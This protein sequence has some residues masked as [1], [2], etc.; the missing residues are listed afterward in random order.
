MPHECKLLIA[1]SRLPFLLWL[2]RIRRRGCWSHVLF[3]HHRKMPG[4]ARTRIDLS[5]E[6]MACGP[7]LSEARQCLPH[8]ETR[9]WLGE[10]APHLFC[11]ARAEKITQDSSQ[12]F[13]ALSHAMH[14]AGLVTS[15]SS[16]SSSSASC[17]SSASQSVSHTAEG[18]CPHRTK[19]ST[20]ANASGSTWIIQH[21]V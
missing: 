1:S 18:E 4:A 11:E 19:P 15:T 5:P 7:R 3:C 17:S 21:V 9:F 20:T 16:S 6:S 10:S 2:G 8:A 12:R 14:L 13:K